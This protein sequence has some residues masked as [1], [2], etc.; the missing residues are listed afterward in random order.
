M[1]ISKAGRFENPVG[2]A[3]THPGNVVLDGPFKKCHRLRQ[4]AGNLSE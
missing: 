3:F 2:I 1:N 4:I